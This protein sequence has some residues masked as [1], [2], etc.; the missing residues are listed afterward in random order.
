MKAEKRT[1]KGTFQRKIVGSE[2]IN[3]RKCVFGLFCDV[4]EIERI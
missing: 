2:Y 4:R 1:A 3:V